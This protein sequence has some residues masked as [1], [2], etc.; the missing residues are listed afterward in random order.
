MPR[1]FFLLSILTCATLLN[2]Q[3]DNDSTGIVV[4]RGR[5]PPCTSAFDAPRPTTAP[6]GST[7]PM[8]T[9]LLRA[10]RRLRLALADLLRHPASGGRQETARTVESAATTE[11][12]CTVRVRGAAS[13]GTVVGANVPRIAA[14]GG[15]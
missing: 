1:A 13:V 10:V 14:E 2:V 9:S 5:K 3:G 11:H 12:P 4:G 7:S 15:K 6:V 8:W